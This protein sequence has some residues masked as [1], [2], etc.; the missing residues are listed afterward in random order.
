MAYFDNS[1]AP[2]FIGHISAKHDAK[3]LVECCIRGLLKPIP[4][5]LRECERDKLIQSGNVFIYEEDSSRITRWT[6][7]KRWGPSRKDG[8]FLIYK[9]TTELVTKKKSKTESK[10]KRSNR[11]ISK[12]EPYGRGLA[13]SP[14]AS[15][16]CG[17]RTASPLT[18]KNAESGP[19]GAVNNKPQQTLTK[20]SVAITLGQ[21]RFHLVSY[22]TL[23]DIEKLI[24]PSGT[25]LYQNVHPRS[26]LNGPTLCTETFRTNRALNPTSNACFPHKANSA[27]L[28]SFNPLGG[29]RDH[30]DAA[31]NTCEQH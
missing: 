3:I 13:V 17:R 29:Y 31:A 22:Y 5:R 12:P 28:P 27:Y 6:D 14:R 4:R 15:G 7:G 8:D 1:P 9:E 2:T 11:G 10:T 21:S 18:T 30:M 24:T 23:E 16:L 26:D 20:K 25:P 19:Q